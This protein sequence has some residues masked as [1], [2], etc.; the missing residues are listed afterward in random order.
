M[1]VVWYKVGLQISK[2]RTL[3]DS[4]LTIFASFVATIIVG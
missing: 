2:A 3:F 4:L 1:D